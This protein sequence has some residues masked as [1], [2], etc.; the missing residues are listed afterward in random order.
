MISSNKEPQ[1]DIT[2]IGHVCFDEITPFRGE[3][4]ISPGSAVLCGA[5]VSTRIGARTAVITKMN[6]DDETIVKPLRDLGADVY[7]VPA[8]VTTI[9]RVVHA[10]S[11]VD[12]RQLFMIQDPGPF[13]AADIPPDL[14]TKIV[15]LAGI[16]DHEFTL[17]LIKDLRAAGYNLSLDLQSFVRVVGGDGE[18]IFSDVL[19]KTEIVAQLDFVKLDAFEARVLTGLED[20]PSAGRSVSSWGAPEVLITDKRGVTLISGDIVH[21][22]PFTN[23]NQSGRTGRGDTT[24]AAYLTRRITHS[25]IEA[26]RFAAATASIKMETPGPFSKELTDV[27]SRMLM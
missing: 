11:D 21:H 26:V 25:P 18:I 19:Q 10:S 6:P 24:M 20:I 3:T 23:R 7:V 22:A 16:S 2:F 15:H 1:Y 12:E 27:E 8:D 13:T 9:S 5:M 17:E 14:T 4:S